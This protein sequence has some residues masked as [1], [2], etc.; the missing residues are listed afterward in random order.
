MN[1]DFTTKSVRAA[2]IL[3]GSYVAG[4]VIDTGGIYNQVLLNVV[5]TKGSLTSAEIKIEF[6]S[7][8]LTFYQET[9]P[10]VSTGTTTETLAEHQISATGNYRIPVPI[11]DR[12][13]KISA[14][15][16]G[17]ATGSSMTIDLSLGRI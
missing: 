9:N 13:I 11:L 16:T 5:Y 17:T 1:Q 12:Y 4:T 2:A 7:D 15:G 14:K 8:N 6:S 10:S 3:T